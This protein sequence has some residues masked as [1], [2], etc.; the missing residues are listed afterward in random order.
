MKLWST[1]YIQSCE[2]VVVVGGGPTTSLKMDY[3]VH[4]KSEGYNF[5]SA[6]YDHP[7]LNLD[8]IHCV[9]PS[10]LLECLK[11]NPTCN[12]VVVRDHYK[13]NTIIKKK[14]YNN[15]TFY[16]MGN[17]QAKT[18]AY[19]INKLK[20][21]ECGFF[22]YY[23]VGNA[24]FSSLVIS[25]VLRPSLI[26]MVGFDGP[27]GDEFTKKLTYKNE[28]KHYNKPPL[29]KKRYLEKVIIPFLHGQNIRLQMFKEDAFW[30]IDK[31]KCGIEII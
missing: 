24:G 10:K 21:S 15:F 7:L 17:R 1:K 5:I 31:K 4:L 20:C 23:N 12:S 27:H 3:L 8:F 18:G 16:K 30:Q 14:E 2:K 25:S 13:I 22:D 29:Q 19:G 6:N 26:V 28:E 9:T 11:S